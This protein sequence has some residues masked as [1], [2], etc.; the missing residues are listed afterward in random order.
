[1][2]NH[3]LGQALHHGSWLASGALGERLSTAANEAIADILAHVFDG[4]PSHGKVLDEQ[5][6]P[7]GC[8]RRMDEYQRSVS[9]ACWVFGRAD[10]ETG[11][12]L[13]E[14]IW[15]LRDQLTARAASGRGGGH[16]RRADRAPAHARGAR[17]RL[18]ERVGGMAHFG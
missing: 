9:D 7:A 16:Q 13:R 4:D 17:R 14:L 1:V 11:Q 6:A 18:Q 8:R 10:H 12:A 5:G 15:T 3:E 2:V